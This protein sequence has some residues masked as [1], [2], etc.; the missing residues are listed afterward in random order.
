[1]QEKQLKQNLDEQAE[2]DVQV[3]SRHIRVATA[4]SVVLMIIYACHFVMTD[5]LSTSVGDA[6]TRVAGL[7]ILPFAIA[8]IIDA[9]RLGRLLGDPD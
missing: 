4:V 7:M 8:V 3:V 1:M 9:R 6:Q 2:Q 5:D